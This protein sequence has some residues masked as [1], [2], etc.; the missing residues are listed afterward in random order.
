[1]GKQTINA[2]ATDHSPGSFS[3]GL[4]PLCTRVLRFFVLC[5]VTVSTVGSVG[6]ESI[7]VKNAVFSVECVPA[8]RSSRPRKRTSNNGHFKAL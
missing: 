3:R 1:M 5:V 6:K 4:F 7:F 2:I 8:K